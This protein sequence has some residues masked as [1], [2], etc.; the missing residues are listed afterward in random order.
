MIFKFLKRTL[1]LVGLATAAYAAPQAGVA[2]T[3]ARPAL[4]EVSDPDTTIYLF[5]TIHLLPE[6]YEWKGPTLQGA[7]NKSN[8]LYVE[9]IVDPKNPAELIA[10]LTKLGYSNGLPPILDRVPPQ[11]RPLLQAAIAKSGIPMAAF[12]RME[13]WAAAFTLLG[14][15]YRSIGLAGE[16]GVE[17]TL[18]D[19]FGAEG[20]PIGQLETNAE[21]LGFFDKLPES[22]QRSL[23][24]GAIEG[25]NT[26][27]PEFAQMLRGWASGDVEAIA[28]TFN[29]DLS[30]SPELRKALLENRNENW[31]RWIEQRLAQPGT[32]MI[33]V[34]AGHLAGRDSVLAMLQRAGYR[35]Q[36]IQ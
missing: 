25:S 32:I 2:P 12:D 7:I 24:E 19:S 1:A 11:R 30:G 13:T 20:K 23:L 3:T 28:K 4:W 26:A 18:R 29:H 31:S 34:G 15:Q 6:N 27:G 17:Q 8:E 14:V 35:V 22:A 5:G 9:T 33:A 36:R 21:Q 16:N 10:A